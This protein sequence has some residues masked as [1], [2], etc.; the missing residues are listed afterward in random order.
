MRRQESLY[1]YCCWFIVVVIIRKVFIKEALKQTISLH[2]QSRKEFPSLILID[3]CC[4]P[5]IDNELG[6]IVVVSQFEFPFGFVVIV[7]PSDK[8]DKIFK[9]L[10]NQLEAEFFIFWGELFYC[11][12]GST[13]MDRLIRLKFTYS[14]KVRPEIVEYFFRHF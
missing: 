10:Y 9:L 3:F 14:T 5:A 7:V 8:I 6:L 1:Y 12:V 4:F 13:Q 11:G 2:R